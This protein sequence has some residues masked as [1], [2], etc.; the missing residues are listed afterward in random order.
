M[1][2]VLAAAAAFAVSVSSFASDVEK[3]RRWADQIVDSLIDGDAVWL[4][5]GDHEF[6][7]I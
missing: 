6:L 7:G 4:S 5:A 1:L 3:E 2:R